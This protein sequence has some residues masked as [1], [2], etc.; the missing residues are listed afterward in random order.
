[1]PVKPRN[2]AVEIIVVITGIKVAIKD[3]F[4][5]NCVAGII[6]RARH[7][8]RPAASRAACCAAFRP[9]VLVSSAEAHGSAKKSSLALG[10]VY[11]AEYS[12]GALNALFVFSPSPVYVTDSLPPTSSDLAP[13]DLT[14]SRIAAVRFLPLT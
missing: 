1:M 11:V 2:V 4:R 8:A 14:A 12:L 6:H 13:A 5:R 10:A 3:T 7:Y 9:L